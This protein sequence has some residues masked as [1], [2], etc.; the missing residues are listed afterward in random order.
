MTGHIESLRMIQSACWRELER[1]ARDRDHGWHLLGVATVDDDAPALRTVVLR[2][3]D[4]RQ[5]RLSF[6]TDARSPK[7]GQVQ[8]NPNA[9]LL[10][11][12]PVLHWQL[13]L[14]VKLTV[15]TSGPGVA[16]RWAGFR[17][18]D[19]AQ[20]YLSPRAPGSLLEGIEPEP[21]DRGH[22]AVVHAQVLSIDWLELLADGRRRAVFDGDGMRWVTP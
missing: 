13:R 15:E 3:V 9:A 22:F 20:D 10:A 18:T 21:A 17:Q 2:E 19:A 6:Y 11:W 5:N 16:A 12:S 14:R 1:A 8:R 4:E 7:V